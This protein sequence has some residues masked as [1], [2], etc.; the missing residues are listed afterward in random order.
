M[1]IVNNDIKNEHHHNI[2]K[3]NICFEDKVI[4]EQPRILVNIYEVAPLAFREVRKQEGI[5]EKEMIN[6]FLPSNNNSFFEGSKGKSGSL[7]ISTDDK[8][9]ILKSMRLEELEVMIDTFLVDYLNY[10]HDHKS[11]LICKIYGIYKIQEGE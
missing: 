7:F 5:N 11:T 4:E 8:R 9:Y 6:S 10:I 1:K 3:E 2:T